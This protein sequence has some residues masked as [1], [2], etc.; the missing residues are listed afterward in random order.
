MLSEGKVTV[1]TGNFK[2]FGKPVPLAG[3]ITVQWGPALGAYMIYYAV[4]YKS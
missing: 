3:E 4:S 2:C 1:K